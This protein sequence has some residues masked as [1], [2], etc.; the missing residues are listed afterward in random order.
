MN[1][2]TCIKPGGCTCTDPDATFWLCRHAARIVVHDS[3][4]PGGML[5]V[6]HVPRNPWESTA[7]WRRRVAAA[8]VKIDGIAP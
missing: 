8:S 1:D 4:M 5:I 6:P 7:E 3:V 2:R